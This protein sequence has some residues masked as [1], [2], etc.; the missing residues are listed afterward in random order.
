[1]SKSVGIVVPT[2]GERPGYLN[3]CLES[4]GAAGNVHVCLVAPKGFNADWLMSNGLANQ[5][6]IDPGK[7]LAG[8]INTGISELPQSIQYVGWLG[9]DDLLAPYAVNETSEV[10]DRNPSTVLVYGACDYIDDDGKRIWTNRSG[11]W[12][13]WVLPFG[14]DLV[15]Q[16]GALFRR[17]AFEKVGG[18]SIKYGWAFDFDLLLKLR[19]MGR[20]QYVPS[21]LSKFRWH[22]TSLTVAQ[23]AKSVAEASVV[24]VSHLP[25]PVRY[26]SAMWEYPVKKATL[27]AGRILSSKLS[28]E[29]K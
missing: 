2:L 18:L 15:P 3:E 23:R 17:G 1:M 11:Q 10:L 13:S 7:G 26:I 20:L 24:R 12:A 6:V 19:K 9:D 21:I 22:R 25:Q 4:I 14:P 16:P 5:L 28:R 8:A 29:R 27:I